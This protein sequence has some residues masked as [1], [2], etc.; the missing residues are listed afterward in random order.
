MI[1]LEDLVVGIT[2][3]SQVIINKS[4]MYGSGNRDHIYFRFQVGENY[5]QPL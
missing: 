1:A 3:R 5:V 2:N 4:F